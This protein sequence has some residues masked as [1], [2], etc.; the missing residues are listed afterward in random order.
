MG[1]K[2][3]KNEAFRSVADESCLVPEGAGVPWAGRGLRGKG[4]RPACSL[5]WWR[6]GTGYAIKC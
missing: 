4:P 6:Q 5:K 1:D 3:C 2:L